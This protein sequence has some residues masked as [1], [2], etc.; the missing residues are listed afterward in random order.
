MFVT[1]KSLGQ[2]LD[3]SKK[4][5]VFLKTFNSEFSYTEVSF[6]DQNSRPLE[7]EDK[8]NIKLAIN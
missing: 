2:L 4:R 1:N 5:F 8:I 6:T 3:I 7:A